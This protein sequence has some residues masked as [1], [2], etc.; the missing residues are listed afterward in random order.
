MKHINSL[1]LI[2]LASFAFTGCVDFLDKDSLTNPSAGSYW[3]TKGEAESALLGTYYKLREPI[4]SGAM[5][6][7]GN[8]LFWDVLSDNALTTSNWEG[9]DAIMK[10][11]FDASSTAGPISK[12]WTICFQGIS[13]CNFFLNNVEK[14]PNLVKADLDRMEGEALFLRAYYYNELVQLYGAVPLS[15][16][17]E[18]LNSNYQNRPR[19]P[20]SEV[21]VQILKDLDKAIELLPNVAYTDGH[22]VQ[23]SA[24]ALKT[25]VLLNNENYSD[26][27]ETAWSLIGAVDN[28]FALHTNYAGIFFGE[29]S[30]NKEI[31]F[32]IQFKAPDDFHSLDQVIGG[33]MAIFPTTDVRD[34]YEPNDP[35]KKMSLFEEG[36]SWIYST[37]GTFGQKNSFAEGQIPFV[38]MA[39]KKYVNPTI[40]N[41]SGATTS[42]QHFVKIRYADLLLM[43]AEAML[44]GGNGSDLRALEALNDVRQREGVMMPKKTELT[45]EIIRNE[46][47]VELAFEGLRYNDLIRWKIA[48]KVISS[49]AYDAKGNKRKFRSYLFPVPLSEMDKMQGTWEQNADYLK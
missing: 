30:N 6:Q 28:P 12:M 35:R 3:K 45:R 38:K 11:D 41:A 31:M 39:I 16:E 46:R 10:G 19:S 5:G 32:S 25:R 20:K 24:I 15:V 47:R 37:D 36:D 17:Q 29:Q 13:Q 22:A 42:D 40:N 21:V 27:A 26:A 49:L 33:R 18:N 4:L 34:A 1:I 14:V 8:S 43:Y 9:F 44:E 7:S 2:I 48:D 23:G